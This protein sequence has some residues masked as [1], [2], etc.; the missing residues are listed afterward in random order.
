MTERTE[1]QDFA[2]QIA[3]LTY[4]ISKR[5]LLE[6]MRQRGVAEETLAAFERLPDEVYEDHL[7]LH[8]DLEAFGRRDG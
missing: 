6:T 8:A 5:T 3:G 2:R 1:G 7:S 4:P